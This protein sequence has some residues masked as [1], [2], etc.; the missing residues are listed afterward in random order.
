VDALD[1]AEGY[2]RSD[3]RPGVVLAGAAGLLV[4]VLIAAAV[5]TAFEATVT[6][7][8]PRIGP[9]EEL[10]QGLQGGPQPTPPG[11]RLEA[12][13]GENLGPYLAVQRQKLSTYRWVDRQAGVVAIPIERAMD[14]VAEQGLPARPAPPDLGD[15]APSGSSSGRVD[16]AYP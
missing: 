15:R 9:P 14:L 3:I 5:I 16:E 8:A 13:P 2:E 4:F 6:G 12:Q 11:P 7:I 1:L 10:T